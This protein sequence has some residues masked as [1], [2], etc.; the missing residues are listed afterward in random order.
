MFFS[1]KSKQVRPERSICRTSMALPFCCLGV[2]YCGSYWAEFLPVFSI[3]GRGIGGSKLSL[4]T[5]KLDDC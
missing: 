1:L 5:T 3:S 2:H 4:R